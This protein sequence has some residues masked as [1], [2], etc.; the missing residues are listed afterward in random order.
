M[1]IVKGIYKFTSTP[2]GMKPA[3]SD[4]VRT[5][6]RGAKGTSM[7]AFPWMSEQD[8]NDVIDYVIL[9]SQRGEVETSVTT[10]AESDYEEDEDIDPA[11]FL[12]A[13]ASVQES[14]A[15]GR[16]RGRV[17]GQCRAGL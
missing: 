2:Y 7:P 4:L 17:A 16:R 10:I 11:D 14:W 9:L 15:I 8:L 12:D 13:L 5:I 3:R 1:T 6:R